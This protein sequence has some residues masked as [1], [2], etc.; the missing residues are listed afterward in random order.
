MINYEDLKEVL[1]EYMSIEYLEF[2]DKCYE[3]ALII[4]KDMKRMTGDDYITHPLGV[5]YILAEY[6]MDPIT[7][8]CALIHEA[9]TLDKMTY[10]EVESKFGEEAAVILDSISKMR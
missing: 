2:I 5:A 6:K 7:I 4:Y 1:K 10:E 9:I 3:E 8:G